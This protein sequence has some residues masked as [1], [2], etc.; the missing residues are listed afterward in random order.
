[1]SSDEED[2]GDRFS[3]G[4]EG[5]R[6]AGGDPAADAAGGGG[7]GGAGGK[8]GKT[9]G[10]TG[11]GAGPLAG[12]PPGGKANV[13]SKK[14]VDPKKSGK[15]ASKKAT[16][17]G[18]AIGA[19]GRPQSAQSQEQ[20]RVDFMKTV[21]RPPSGKVSFTNQS[22]VSK[23]TTSVQREKAAAGELA[24]PGGAPEKEQFPDLFN[25]E[26]KRANNFVIEAKYTPHFEMLKKEMKKDMVNGLEAATSDPKI[27]MLAI[28]V[29]IDSLKIEILI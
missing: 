22:P 14:S 1:M 23:M 19:D 10:K 11:P 7:Q 29:E 6:G 12:P 16:T 24:P 21:G 26:S 9:G 4:E 17:G 2:E 5:G 28:G 27:I 13:D 15:A 25:K 3:G 18:N 20:M 8:T